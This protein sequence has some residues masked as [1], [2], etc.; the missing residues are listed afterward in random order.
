MGRS[1]SVRTDARRSARLPG[2]AGANQA[3]WLAREN[4]DDPL[5]RARWARR[6]RASDRRSCGLWRR[7]A[8][9]RGP[10]R[11][12]PA[13]LSRSFR[14]TASGA[15]SP[16][17]PRTFI[18][19]PPTCRTRCS[20]AS[21]WCTSPAMHC[22]SRVRARRCSIS[23]GE[24]ERRKIPFAVDP[25]SYSFLQEVGPSQ[26]LDWTRKA[27]FLFPNEDE[28]AVL[29]GE[30]GL[31]AQLDALTKNYPL[32]VLKRGADGAIAAEAATGRRRSVPAPDANV[33][34]TSGA[35]DAFLGGF[36]SAYLRGEGIEAS[37][38][39]AVTLGSLAVT[40][41]GARP[42]LLT[43]PRSI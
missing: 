24:V 22:S 8:A 31:S 9:R 41:L 25:A 18:F 17:A 1:R 4:V 12:R 10:D 7:C 29:T 14:P 43:R 5:R 16:T 19:N 11:S 34:D 36:L 3:C 38:A 42:P 32:V 37:L 30:A 6:S 13:R 21:I 33:L 39:R 28:A 35:G 15:F 27:S 40:M 2:G 20:T 26:F 23:C